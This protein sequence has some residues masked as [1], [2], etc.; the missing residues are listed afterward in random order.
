MLKESEDDNIQYRVGMML[1]NGKGVEKDLKKGI[2]FLEASA[3]NGNPNAQYQ[4]AKIYLDSGEGDPVKINAAIKY[5]ENVANKG[6]N[7]MAH[8]QLGKL[9]IDKQFLYFNAKKGIEHLQIAAD[10]NNEYAQFRLGILYLQGRIVTRNLRIAEKYLT[11]SAENGNEY[12]ADVLKQLKENR[13]KLKGK[14]YVMRSLKV[15]IGNLKSILKN[16]KEKA[17]NMKIY[18]ENEWNAEM[19]AK[20]E[21]ESEVL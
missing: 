18:R 12:A 6:K 10:Q 21:R 1:I 8:Y 19:K 11:Q 9:Y 7:S 13:F 3:E 14:P 17:L 20:K 15:S 2:E 16:E 5:L 4:I